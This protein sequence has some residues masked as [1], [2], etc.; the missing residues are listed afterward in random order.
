MQVVLTTPA[1]LVNQPAGQL[2]D[3][4]LCG[5][6]RG[7]GPSG[8]LGASITLPIAFLQQSTK[9]GFVPASFIY[10]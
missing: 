1:N 6:A 7:A 4:G 5:T 3:P 8:P 9:M 2:F 10:G